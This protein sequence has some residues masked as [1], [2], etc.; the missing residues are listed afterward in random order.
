MTIKDNNKYLVYSLKGQIISNEGKYI[1]LK[2]NYFALITNNNK[3]NLYSYKDGK[4][5][6][7]NKDLIINNENLSNSFEINETDNN[8]IITIINKDEKKNYIFDKTT[9]NLI[10]GENGEE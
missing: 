3:F 4:K 9:G 5:A 1:S 8:Y 2:D 10:S 6:L 7:L